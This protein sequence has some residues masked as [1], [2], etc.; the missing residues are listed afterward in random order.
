[1][2][3]ISKNWIKYR[4]PRT[5]ELNVEQVCTRV[6]PSGHRVE[7]T[8]TQGDGRIL[9][10]EG[11]RHLDLDLDE[12]RAMRDGLASSIALIEAQIAGSPS[13]E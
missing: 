3:N 6:R 1:M 7:V 13:K 9:R 8:I 12:A 11:F 4:S 5:A 2:A 10:N